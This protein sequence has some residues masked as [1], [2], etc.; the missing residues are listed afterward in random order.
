M[1]HRS[2]ASSSMPGHGLPAA[3][4]VGIV[5]RTHQDL[6]DREAGRRPTSLMASTLGRVVV[7]RAMSGWFVTTTSN[8]PASASRRQASSTPGSMI[9]LVGP[10]RRVAARPS[11]HAR[12]RFKHAVAVE[13]HRAPLLLLTR[14]A[15]RARRRA[16]RGSTTPE[17]VARVVAVL[18]TEGANAIGRDAHDGYVTLPS[19]V[20]TAVDELDRRADRDRAHST[21]NRRSRATVM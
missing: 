2:A 9:D 21:A 20:P 7:P 8:H 10:L 15:R 18:P 13:E 11:S 3:A 12:H 19:P 5:V 14:A 4:R 16:W 17:R 1:S 6:G